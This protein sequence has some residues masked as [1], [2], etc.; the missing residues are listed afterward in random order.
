MLVR[1]E[2]RGH[3]PLGILLKR[4]RRIAFCVMIGLMRVSGFPARAT[5]DKQAAKVYGE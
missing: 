1:D 4:C 2:S 5:A 3:R